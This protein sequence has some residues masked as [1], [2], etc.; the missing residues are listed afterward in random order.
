MELSFFQ[1]LKLLFDS[2][3]TFK[4]WYIYPLIYFNL[5]KSDYSIFETFDNIKLK[6]RNHSTDLMTLTNVWIVKEYV[7]EKI[8]ISDDDTIIDIGGHIGLFSL[9]MSQYCKKG[10]IF[11]YEPVSQNFNLL[12]SNISL[13]QS[14]NIMP[15]N[16]AV[17]DKSSKIKIFLNDDQSGHSIISNEGP[18]EII[19]S[20]QLKEIFEQNK[21]H[22]CNLLKLDCEGAEYAIIES[23]PEEYFKKIK[24]IM[25][26]YHFADSKPE[27]SRNL[28]N[29][30]RNVGFNISLNPHHNDMGFLFGIN[31]S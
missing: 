4:N 9:F 27:L 28:I 20:I 7:N 23:L 2:R 10:K 18:S 29:K 6:I 11:S 13:N 1:K 19:D 12:R 5:K 24:K 16:F 30:L 22:V 26:E 15:F 25:I 3:K 31:N 21:I 8:N 17:S 14:K